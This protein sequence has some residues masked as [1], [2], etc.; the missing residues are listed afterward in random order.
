MRVTAFALALLV[1]LTAGVSLAGQI[2]AGRVRVIP[3]KVG[4]AI[5]ERLLPDDQVVRLD[6]PREDTDP[7]EQP[8]A[9]AQLRATLD[10]SE[11]VTT[12]IAEEVRG[13]LVED[14]SWVNTRVVGRVDRPYL[15]RARSLPFGGLLTLE[16]SGGEL[17]LGDTL[18]KAWEPPRIE[19]DKRYLVFHSGQ[20]A[21]GTV[22][23]YRVENGKLASTWPA[24]RTR[25]KDALDGASFDDVTEQ[26]S[27]RR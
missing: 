16:F 22:A 4:L 10:A 2:P 6:R 18:V 12:V 5:P 19:K 9:E 7:K 26:V 13:V 1:S 17:P 8:T 3:Y 20:G 24:D 14:G 27:R 11:I 21:L 15:D 25:I 23:V